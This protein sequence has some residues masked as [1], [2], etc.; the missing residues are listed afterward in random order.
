MPVAIG[1]IVALVSLV[2]IAIPFIRRSGA[3]LSA[4]HTG[5]VERLTRLRSDL[6]DQ[7]GQL[8]AD[9]AAN[10]V[11]DE[12]YQHQLLELRIG[13]AETI[14]QLDQLGYEEEPQDAPAP[15]TRESLEEEI[16][17]LRQAGS[18]RDSATDEESGSDGA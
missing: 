9:H 3:V 10:T 11:T 2:V 6:Y 16:A 1:A 17:A 8:Q 18:R 15:L 5:E 4:R 14:R 12:D 13:A 7:I